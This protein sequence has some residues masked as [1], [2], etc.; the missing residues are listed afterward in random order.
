MKVE[1]SEILNWFAT[2]YWIKNMSFLHKDFMFH[3]ASGKDGGD[4][5]YILLLPSSLQK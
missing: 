4:A 5:T 3:N 1:G 2:N